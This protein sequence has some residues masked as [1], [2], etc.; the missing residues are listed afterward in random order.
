[1]KKKPL[2]LP[3]NAGRTITEPP[4]Q[5]RIQNILVTTDLSTESITGVRYAVALAENVGA[6]VTLLHV[7]ALITSGSILGMQT[8]LLQNSEVTEYARSRLKAI[9]MQ[10]SN[11]NLHLT[12]LLR[13]G[14][15][16]HGIIT[17]ARKRAADL[18][19]IA[20]HGCTGAKRVLLGSTAERVVRHAS[21]PVLTVPTR[22]TRRR[23]G[24]ALRSS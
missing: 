16:F 11:V 3:G 2:K 12:P 24:S 23:T 22:I 6:A 18:I 21:C 8:V 15:A 20:T 4:A 10:E 1:M 5:L 14:N 19:V 17:A 13:T 9:A 7:V